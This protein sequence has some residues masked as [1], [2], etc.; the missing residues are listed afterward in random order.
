MYT[1]ESNFNSIHFTF[2]IKLKNKH[3]LI[4]NVMIVKNIK[5]QDI[6]PNFRV[7]I[8][9]VMTLMTIPKTIAS[10]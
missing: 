2:C 6:F 1:N 9:I 7:S 4:V 10:C 8:L 3:R 5:L